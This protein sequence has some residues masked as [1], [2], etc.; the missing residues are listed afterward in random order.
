MLVYLSKI[1]T[2]PRAETGTKKISKA[3]LGVKTWEIDAREPLFL[4][5]APKKISNNSLLLGL[6]G[7]EF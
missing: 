4:I 2:M 7:R 1:A 3:G 5:K 6:A